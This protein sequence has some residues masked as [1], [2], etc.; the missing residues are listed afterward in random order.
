MAIDLI[1]RFHDQEDVKKAVLGS[2]LKY[3]QDLAGT[4]ALQGEDVTGFKDAAETINRYFMTLNTTYG[5][6]KSKPENN[7]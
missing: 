7:E 2:M 4:K 6:K 3:C 5:Q 1:K